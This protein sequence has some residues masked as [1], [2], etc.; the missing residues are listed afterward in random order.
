MINPLVKNLFT[1]EPGDFFIASIPVILG[2]RA[3][4]TTMILVSW[5]LIRKEE[6]RLYL[7]WPAGKTGS[8][9]FSLSWRYCKPRL[10]QKL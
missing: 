2:S 9:I 7:T 3:S 8:V 5:I 4:Y 10:T 6:V 1:T